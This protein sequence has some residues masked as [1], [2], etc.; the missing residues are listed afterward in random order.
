MKEKEKKS[1]RAEKETRPWL[2]MEATMTVAAEEKVVQEREELVR[3]GAVKEGVMQLSE[4]DMEANAR[5]KER[6]LRFWLS[7]VSQPVTLH[8]YERCVTSSSTPRMTS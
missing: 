2:E 8:M 4:E 6:A 1:I 5:L 3:G 7:V